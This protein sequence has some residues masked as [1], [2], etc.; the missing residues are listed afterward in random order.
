M[1]MKEKQLNEIFD[2]CC[3]FTLKKIYFINV[4]I[5]FSEMLKGFPEAHVE[6]AQRNFRPSTSPLTHS[7][8]S[9]TSVHSAER[10]C[11]T[12]IE[13]CFQIDVKWVE[14]IDDKEA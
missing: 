10:F 8:P 6:D 4:I 11:I 7:S 5:S 13:M 1:E 9:Q 2:W 14:V 12:R 3:K